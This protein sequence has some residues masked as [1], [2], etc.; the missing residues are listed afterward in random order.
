MVIIAPL[1]QRLRVEAFVAR[2]VVNDRDTAL[3]TEPL[4]VGGDVRGRVAQL[5]LP[6]QDRDG[7]G[8]AM[9]DKMG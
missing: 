2:I 7:Q 3:L 1:R 6:R 5:D 9:V 8:S 4:V